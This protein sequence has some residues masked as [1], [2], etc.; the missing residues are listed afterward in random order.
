MADIAK[1][2]DSTKSATAMC[3]ACGGASDDWWE[4]GIN[5]NSQPREMVS[6]DYCPLHWH[7]DCLDPPRASN[8]KHTIEQQDEI[9]LVGKRKNKKKDKSAV[10]TTWM[11]PNHITDDPNRENR[12]GVSRAVTGGRVGKIR[13]PKHATIKDVSLRRGFHNNGLIEVLND[14]SDTEK[15]EDEPGVIYRLPEKSIKL[16][17]IDRIKQYVPVNI[18]ILH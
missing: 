12:Q 15:E 3:F 13:R 7:L 2:R 5:P 16:D 4:D 6:C 1:F 10:V 9:G 18:S 17:F 14:L 8:P 11:C